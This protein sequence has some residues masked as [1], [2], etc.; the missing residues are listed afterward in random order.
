MN[1][2]FSEVNVKKQIGNAVPPC[3]AKVLFS[4]IRKA[5]EEADGIE[6]ENEQS[7]MLHSG[8]FQTEAIVLD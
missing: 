8:N 4:W 7:E 3:V 2:R 6:P 1:H 5:L